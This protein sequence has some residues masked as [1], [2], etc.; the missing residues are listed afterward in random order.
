MTQRIALRIL[1]MLLTA[2]GLIFVWRAAAQGQGEPDAAALAR[3]EEKPT[4]L[5]FGASLCVEC[6]KVHR[7]RNLDYLCRCIEYTIWDKEDKLRDAYN[8]LQGEQAR[9][10]G[11]IL[12]WDNVAERKECLACHSVVIPDERFLHRSFERTEGISC[13]ICPGV[14]KDWVGPHY[15]P[16]DRDA[17]RLLPRTAKEAK[18]GMADLWDPVKRARLCSS[19][20]VG[21]AAQGKFVTHAMY[22]VGHPPRLGF[23]R[24]SSATGCVT[25]SICTRRMRPSRKSC[26][27][28]DESASRP[29][30]SSSAPPSLPRGK[31]GSAG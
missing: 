12:K 20:H 9:R 16:V 7:D 2:G 22:A 24:P 25:G 19:C 4:S 14:Y 31:H 27:T 29:S 15:N 5:Y 26:N 11:A 1:M 6:L 13:A 21:K 28:R 3:K 17:W 10:M 8:V 30:S 18:Y 23:S